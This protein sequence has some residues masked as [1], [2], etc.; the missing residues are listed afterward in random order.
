MK[1]KLLAHIKQRDDLI[2]NSHY[3]SESE[4]KLLRAEGDLLR[5][6]VNLA[7]IEF[8]KFYVDSCRFRMFQDSLYT[9]DIAKNTI[10]ALGNLINIIG[11]DRHKPKLNGP[12][13]MLT[14]ISGGLIILTPILSR[15][16]GKLDSMSRYRAL[17]NI[18]SDV[19]MVDIHRFELDRLRLARLGQQVSFSSE[20]GQQNFIKRLDIY[21]QHQIR[22]EKQLDLA[23]REVRAG[24]RVATENVAS[25]IIIG[26]TKLGLGVPGMV[27][28]FKYPHNHRAAD[29]LIAA[30]S[31]S[32]CSGTSYA[33][34]DN[35][36]IQVVNE[37]NRRK[38]KRSRRLPVQVFADRINDLERLELSFKKLGT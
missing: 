36:R 31:I 11:I 1:V 33:L 21:E 22:C 2:N 6:V 26:S 10:G 9:L 3:L 5:D 32:Y 28:G 7:L 8:V 13:F 12:G 27:A 20:V 19:E 24:V 37:R 35:I 14:T 17:R 23:T 16:F 18:I 34:L 4:K 38:L 15:G 25:G 30:G 29:P